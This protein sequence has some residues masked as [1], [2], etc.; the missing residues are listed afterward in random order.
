MFLSPPMYSTTISSVI[1]RRQSRIS[2]P[3][4]SYFKLYNIRL[5]HPPF[6]ADRACFTA[7]VGNKCRVTQNV[8]SCL[9]LFPHSAVVS[10]IVF[11]KLNW[12]LRQA[13]RFLSRYFPF[14]FFFVSATEQYI[15]SAFHSKHK[16]CMLNS[17]III[18]GPKFWM[19]VRI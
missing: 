10:K 7:L 5:A 18:L 6:F 2:W 19:A 13:L 8:N 11:W 1:I 15:C 9:K 17:V 14:I 4:E 3:A 16:V 12:R